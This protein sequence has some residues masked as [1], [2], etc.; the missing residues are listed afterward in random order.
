MGNLSNMP[1]SNLMQVDLLIRKL[2]I[3][4]TIR[5]GILRF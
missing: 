2:L 4:L 3:H 1:F 5:V